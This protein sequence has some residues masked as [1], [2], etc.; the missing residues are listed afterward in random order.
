MQQ[1]TCILNYIMLKEDY[2]SIADSRSIPRSSFVSMYA[3]IRVK[4]RIRFYIYKSR[5]R[6]IDNICI[7]VFSCMYI[8]ITL[9]Y[10]YT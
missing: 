1:N 2:M 3:G 8:Y 5:Y 10:P 4:R 9:T 7:Y 6:D